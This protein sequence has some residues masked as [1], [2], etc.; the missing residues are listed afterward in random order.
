METYFFIQQTES[1][2]N[3]RYSCNWCFSCAIFVLIILNKQIEEKELNEVLHLTTE[4][5]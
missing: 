5:K 4:L 2:N 1:H 3:L